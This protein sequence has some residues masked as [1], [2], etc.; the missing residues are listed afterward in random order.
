MVLGELLD[1]VGGRQQEYSTPTFVSNDERDQIAKIQ[2]EVVECYLKNRNT[3]L[4]CWRQVEAFKQVA[5]SAQ[6]RFVQA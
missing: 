4:D 2:D 3:P 6:T 1:R 5:R